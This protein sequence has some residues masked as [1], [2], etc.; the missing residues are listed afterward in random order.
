MNEYEHQSLTKG[1]HD[2]SLQFAPTPRNAVS[3]DRI[4]VY[5]R[6]LSD[7][8]LPAVLAALDRCGKTMDEFPAVSAIRKEIGAH[9]VNTAESA[10]TAWIE[11]EREARRVG[12]NR[13]PEF[14]NGEFLPEQKSQFSSDLIA[15]AVA[16]TTWRLICQGDNERGQIAEQFRWNY[17]N[18]EKQAIGEIQRG[19][20]GALANGPAIDEPQLTALP[21]KAS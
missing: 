5:I 1:L 10:E 6:Q 3:K 11:V 16:A 20:I 19:N 8:P 21:R 7:L 4:A 12:Y 17:R 2:L 9:A 13:P 18:L 15:R 14:R